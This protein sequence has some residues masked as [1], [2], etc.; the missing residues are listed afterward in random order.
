MHAIGA[1]NSRLQWIRQLICF[2]Q[3]LRRELEIVRCGITGLL[4]GEQIGIDAVDGGDTDSVLAAER[5][6]LDRR[7]GV[8]AVLA[9]QE[10]R[11][12]YKLR[13]IC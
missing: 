6:Q 5:R 2:Q 1:G 9:E 8:V 3:R 12:R 4:I 11:V 13:G 7:I 10:G